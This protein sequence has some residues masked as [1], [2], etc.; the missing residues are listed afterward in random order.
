MRLPF[1]LGRGLGWAIRA[2]FADIA[3]RGVDFQWSKARLNRRYDFD[4]LTTASV[5]RAQSRLSVDEA[6]SVFS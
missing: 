5:L 6:E 3:A 1:S 2:G 4:V